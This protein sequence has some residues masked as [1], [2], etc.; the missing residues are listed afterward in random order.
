MILGMS[1]LVW[2][3]STLPTGEVERLPRPAGPRH[4]AP[5]PPDGPGLAPVGGHADQFRRQ[6]ERRGHLG[7]LYG[8]GEAPGALAAVLRASL[9][10]AAG[11]AFLVAEML[12]IPCVS[13]VAVIRQETNSWKW[14]ALNMLLL[15]VLALVGGVAAYQAA[16]WVL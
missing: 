11:L 8:V 6:G 5:R 1:V 3:L 7:V 12:F 15:T 10:P 2:A 13:A 16:R 14:A 4:R 9:P